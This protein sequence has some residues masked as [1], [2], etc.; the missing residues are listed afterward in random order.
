MDESNAFSDVVSDIKGVASIVD[1]LTK[2]GGDVEGQIQQ[3]SE[4][5]QKMLANSLAMVQLEHD[6]R[7]KARMLEERLKEVENWEKEKEFYELKNISP[8]NAF[9][10]MLKGSSGTPDTEYRLCATCFEKRKKSI[11]QPEPTRPKVLRCYKCDLEI[12]LI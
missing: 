7:N 5:T 9:A 1:T 8:H 3:L 2:G 10:Y 4:L 11:L 6:L 12:P